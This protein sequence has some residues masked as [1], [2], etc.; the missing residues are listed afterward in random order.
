MILPDFTDDGDIKLVNYWLSKHPNYKI[1]DIAD[2]K[3]YLETYQAKVKRSIWI[4]G[5]FA[6]LTAIA[7]ASV[8][9][10]NPN[11]AQ[12]TALLITIGSASMMF[13]TVWVYLSTHR[14]DPI[15][16][17]CWQFESDW[18]RYQNLNAEEEDLFHI[19]SLIP[20]ATKKGEHDHAHELYVEFKN[21]H[22][23]L[24]KFGMCEPDEKFYL[25]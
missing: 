5:A 1:Q 12:N 8:L 25:S 11:V 13:A 6:L 24:T 7:G 16:K 3:H 23:V 21:T 22:L 19:L 4:S 14:L 2:F 17:L 15:S 18:S 9:R 20:E 10:H